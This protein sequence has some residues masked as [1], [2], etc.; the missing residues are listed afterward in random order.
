MEIGISSDDCFECYLLIIWPCLNLNPDPYYA[1]RQ[2][3]SCL[4]KS[5]ATEGTQASWAEQNH[6]GAPRTTQRRMEARKRERLTAFDWLLVYVF[7]DDHPDWDQA[8]VV[9][10]FA[11]RRE[12]ALKFLQSAL[13]RK[14]SD[15]DGPDCLEVTNTEI[16][17]MC[18][19]LEFACLDKP[20]LACNLELAHNLCVF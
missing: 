11:S 18:E 6:T 5:E 20:D 1:I 12:D 7:V 10:H 8:E 2:K 19:K 14:L 15:D 16:I 9:E 17:E 13:S 4:S 3:A